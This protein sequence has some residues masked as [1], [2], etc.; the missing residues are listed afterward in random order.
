VLRGGIPMGAVAAPYDFTWSFVVRPQ[1]E[2]ASRLMVRE[3][4]R[5]TRRWAPLI[6]QPAELVSCL[7]SARMLRGIKERAEHASPQRIPISQHHSHRPQPGSYAELDQQADA[8]LDVGPV[9]AL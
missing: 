3:R 7:M 2:G 9:A 8:I 6:V 1:P 5:Y 4:Y